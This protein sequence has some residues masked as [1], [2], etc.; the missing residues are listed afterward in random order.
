MQH[1]AHVV[2]RYDRGA[3]GVGEDVVAGTAHQSRQ[4]KTQRCPSVSAVGVSPSTAQFPIRQRTTESGP[5]RP[6]A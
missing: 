2:G 3:A 6:G 4:A 1:S 5:P